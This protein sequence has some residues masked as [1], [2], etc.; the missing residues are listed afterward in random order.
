M[1]CGPIGAADG[2]GG[3]TTDADAGTTVGVADV[4]CGA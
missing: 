3:A 4:D 1:S 2:D